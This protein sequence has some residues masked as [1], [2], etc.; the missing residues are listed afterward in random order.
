MIIFT[1]STFITQWKSLIIYN[2]NFFLYELKLYT[3]DQ[4]REYM[5][6]YMVYASLYFFL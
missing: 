3:F 1:Q 4:D 5:C 6:V 2:P